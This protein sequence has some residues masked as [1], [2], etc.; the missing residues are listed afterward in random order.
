MPRA[1]PDGERATRGDLR[2]AHGICHGRSI[3][4]SRAGRAQLGALPPAPLRCASPRCRLFE[5]RL[6]SVGWNRP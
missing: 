5:G 6:A 3:A 1:G 2:A 4:A